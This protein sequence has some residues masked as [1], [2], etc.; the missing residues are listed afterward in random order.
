MLVH[1]V[2]ADLYFYNFAFRPD[3]SRVQGLVVIA[4]GH[5]DVVIKF[6]RNGLPQGMYQPKHAVTTRQVIN[7]Y[8]HGPD[9]EQLVEVETLA[10]HFSV[11]TVDVLGATLNLTFDVSAC[12]G[13]LQ[14]PDETANEFLTIGASF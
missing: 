1:L 9:I 2:G 12:N 14:L 10:L 8:A 5:R 3:H 7:Q 6:A 4:L 13:S 11:N